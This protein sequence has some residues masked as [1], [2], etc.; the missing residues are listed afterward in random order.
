MYERKKKKKLSIYCAKHCWFPNPIPILPFFL[1]NKILTS[2]KS[3]QKKKKVVK[4]QCFPAS[5]AAK[6]GQLKRAWDIRSAIC[7]KG[8]SENLLGGRGKGKSCLT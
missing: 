6:V 8:C 3:S 2:L 7:R 4:K 1:T 5:L